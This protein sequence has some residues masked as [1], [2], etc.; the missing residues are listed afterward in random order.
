MLERKHTFSFIFF[1]L[2]S[3]SLIVFS[4]TGEWNGG[5]FKE[6][7]PNSE[8][9]KAMEESYFKD[10]LYHVSN[11]EGP[12]L[13]LEA[14]E[15]TINNTIQKTFF[16]NP[17]GYA[18]TKKKDRVE[19]AGKKGI[20]DQSKE[21]LNLEQDTILKT[22][23]TEATAD[24][25]VYQV[26]DDRVHMTD[27][28][29][30]KTFY[31]EEGDWIYLDGDEAYFWLE[32]QRSRYVGNVS[33][34]IK[35]KRV[36][37][38]SMEFKSNELYLNMDLLKADLNHDVWIKKQELTATSR[39]GEIFLENY[40]KKLKYFALYDDVKVVEKVMLDGKFIKRRSFSEKLEGIPSEGKIILTGYPKVYQLSD[41][42]KGNMIVLRENTEVVEVDDANTKFNVE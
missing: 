30:T 18:F 3:T 8:S 38:D 14:T 11:D 41:V 36:Y 17:T 4:F 6:L 9:V 5:I 12:K 16:F 32:Q 35:R 39:R 10:V 22:E 37:E 42:I 23:T 21:I 34:V 1:L 31:V 25:M 27:N 28:V 7:D 13:M 2:V 40:N 15:L 33:G 24:K 20:F 26:Q 19:Y 29:K